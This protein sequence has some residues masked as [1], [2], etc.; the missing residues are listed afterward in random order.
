[1]PRLPVSVPPAKGSFVASATVI[2][3]D[4]LN[5]TPLIVLAVVSVSAFGWYPS[6]YTLLVPQVRLPCSCST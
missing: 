3:A 1:M 2:F 4:P 6:W 5:E